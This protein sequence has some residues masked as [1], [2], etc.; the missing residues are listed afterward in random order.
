MG[1]A[2]RPTFEATDAADLLELIADETRPIGRN[3]VEVFLDACAADA[4]IH[5]GLVSVN[6]VR[7]LVQETGYEISPARYSAFWAHFTGKDR[8][9]RK[10]TTDDVDEPWEVCEGSE[11]NNNGRPY[12]LRVWVG[13]TTNDQEP[14]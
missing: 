14:T 6:R 13:R 7:A 9:M 4:A 1:D 8:P 11:S 10:A 12:R 3:D 2:G 5:D